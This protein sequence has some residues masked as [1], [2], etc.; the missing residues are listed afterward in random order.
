[1]AI[2][3]VEAFLRDNERFLVST[4]LN[5]D[6]DGIGAAMAVKWLL[7]KLGK[8][9]EIA[10]E[11][12]APVSLD[13][14]QDYQWVLKY[15][16]DTEG[17][18]KF[19]SVIMVDTPSME[20]AGAVSNLIESGAGILNVDHHVSNER[21]GSVNLIDLDAASSTQMVYEI[22]RALG[23]SIEPACAEYLFTG[24]VIDTGRFRFSNTTAETFRVAS[25]LVTSGAIP[26]RITER[27]FYYKTL[28]T[29][30]ALGKFIDSIDI[31]LNGLVATAQFDH[32]YIRSDEWRKTSSEGF[33][34]HA[35]SIQGVEVAMFLR[36]VENGVTRASLRAKNDFD[37]NKL[38]GVFGGGG[39]AKAAGCTIRFPLAQAKSKLLDATATQMNAARSEKNGQ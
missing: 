23:M 7:V 19:S 20:R 8:Q 36:E 21:F 28:E 10:L 14:F 6:G 35:L 30:R 11:S 18:G 32:D 12:D 1:M 34:N 24:L 26:S 5:P 33:V 29:T 3:A 16:K 17:M 22:I 25:E 37:V 13:F 4:H 38:A 15:G 27:L 31:H 2:S 9:A 39:H